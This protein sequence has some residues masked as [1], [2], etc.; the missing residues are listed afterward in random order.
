MKKIVFYLIATFLSLTFYLLQSNAA[1]VAEPSS[2]LASKPAGSAEANALLLRLNEIKAMDKSNLNSSEKKELR[3]E[4]R[5]IRQQ[6]R[7]DGGGAYLSVGVI[8][9]VVV[10]IVILL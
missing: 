8:I 9:L 1:T 3:L 5:S 2:L 10:L 4:V 6:L 7:E